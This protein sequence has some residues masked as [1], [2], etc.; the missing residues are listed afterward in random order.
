MS[1]IDE[2]RAHE[3]LRLVQSDPGKWTEAIIG[4]D[5]SVFN[6]LSD[7]EA[8]F[9]KNLQLRRLSPEGR[10]RVDQWFRAYQE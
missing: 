3:L 4:G 9:I 8:T 2:K 1:E 7:Q 6:G 10:I 5:D